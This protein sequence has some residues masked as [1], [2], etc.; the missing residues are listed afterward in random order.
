[1]KLI[2]EFG[3]FLNHS[4]HVFLII[5]LVIEMLLNDV[6]MGD[7]LSREPD[8][9]RWAY[10]ALYCHSRMWADD[11]TVDLSN[12]DSFRGYLR[13]RVE[14]SNSEGD[15]EPSPGDELLNDIDT[16]V[17]W[18]HAKEVLEMLSQPQE[19]LGHIKSWNPNVE[20][21]IL[22]ILEELI[23]GVGLM[24]PCIVLPECGQMT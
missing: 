14:T 16:A 1:M 3:F 17:L 20:K 4:G 18:G 2:Q 9:R 19:L 5:Q 23:F 7:R 13:K 12:V 6:E 22:D 24:M 8:F 10:D 11:L 15:E 21:S